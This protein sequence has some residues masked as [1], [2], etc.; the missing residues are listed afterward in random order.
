MESST[1]EITGSVIVQV[2]AKHVGGWTL[3]PVFQNLFL[4]V[5]KLTTEEMGRLVVFLCVCFKISVVI[6]QGNRN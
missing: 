3:G 2:N 4:R 6:V 1:A 5:D